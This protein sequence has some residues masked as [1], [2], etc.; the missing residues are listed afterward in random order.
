MDSSRDSEFDA[1]LKRIELVLTDLQR[2]IDALTAERRPAPPRERAPETP[3]SSQAWPFPEVPPAPARRRQATPPPIDRGVRSLF[4]SHDAEWWLSRVGIGFLVLGVLLLYGYAVD[5]GWIT[6]PIRVLTGIILGGLLFGFAGRVRSQTKAPPNTDLGFREVLLGG[7]LAIWYVTAY[8]AAVWYQLIPIPAARLIFFALAILSTWIALD[9]NREIFALVAVA[10]GFATPFILPAPVHSMTELSLYLGTVTAI[11]LII[12]LLRGWQ[13]ILWITFA[14]FWMSVAETANAQAIAPSKLLDSFDSVTEWTASP[15]AGVEI[16]IHRD[17]SGAHGRAMR[18]D[19]DFHGNG[20]YAVVHRL[21]Y[22]PLPPNYEFSFGIR[23]DAP[24][25]TLEFKLID[26]TGANVWR[27]NNV[28]FE[29]PRAWTTI[30]IKKRQIPFAWGQPRDFELKRLAAL[31]FA[32]TAGSG[33]KGSVWLDDLAIAPIREPAVGSV[34]TPS[35]RPVHVARVPSPALGSVALSI[36]LLAAAVA[37]T[38]T[39]MLRRK[40]LKIGSP[41]YTSPPVTERSKGFVEAMDSLSAALGGG[42]TAPDSV[43]L[44]VLMLVSA[45]LAITLLGAIWPSV[46]DEIWGA[47]FVVM[48]L[49]AVAYS[50]RGSQPDAEI[51]HVALTAGV[52]WILIG[53]AKLASTPES[54]PLCGVAVA[55]VIN[56]LARHFSGP[57]TLAKFVI[58]LSLFIIAAH[59]LSLVD[60]GF[61]H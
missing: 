46:P 44:W 13:S 6:P 45:A 52:F 26:S 29:F 37:F 30:T 49:G 4:A 48:G 25:N 35:F 18:L 40:L 8:A 55:L 21:M 5:H 19:F 7:A 47:S 1:R 22:L 11:G 28:G 42:K 31:E 50:R 54:L 3:A 57:R 23:G 43:I 60:T 34:G 33:G 10:A 53:I 15:A 27:S 17:S 39:P 24:T 58:A 32:I 59:E 51:A 20:G 41:R 38:R 36:L 56:S 14:A 16:S 2:S 12:Y 61:D 9:E